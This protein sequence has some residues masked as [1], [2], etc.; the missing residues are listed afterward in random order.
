MKFIFV[1]L[2]T[3]GCMAFLPAK[4]E[5]KPTY[6]CMPCGYDCD[7]ESYSA[8]GTCAHC[9]MELVLAS[10]IKFKEVA[11]ENI[12]DYIARHPESILLDVRTREE[13]QGTASPNF[14]T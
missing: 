1:L 5:Y 10:N 13:Y 6:K 11:P 4:I 3:I 9:G 14:G 12:C 7:K 2:A 8:A